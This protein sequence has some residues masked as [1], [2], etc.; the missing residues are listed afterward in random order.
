MNVKKI[1]IADAA[2]LPDE[3]ETLALGGAFAWTDAH[4]ARHREVRIG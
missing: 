4:A 3:A 1:V 2:H